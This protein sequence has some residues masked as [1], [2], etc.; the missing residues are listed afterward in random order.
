MCEK[1]NLIGIDSDRTKSVISVPV[2]LKNLN[3]RKQ[4]DNYNSYKVKIM[5]FNNGSPLRRNKIL[6][7]RLE[8]KRP[9]TFS[10][11][12]NGSDLNV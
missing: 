10:F 3:H 1:S 4:Y 6:L 9:S 12:W 11:G 2:D 5:N 8:Q 7:W